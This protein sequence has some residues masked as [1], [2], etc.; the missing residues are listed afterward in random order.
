[1]QKYGKQKTQKQI[2]KEAFFYNP[3][4]KIE[5]SKKTLIS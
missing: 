1:V 2:L 3:K 4:L 5:A